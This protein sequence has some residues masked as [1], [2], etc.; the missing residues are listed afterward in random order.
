MFLGRLTVLGGV[1]LDEWLEVRLVTTAADD[2]LTVHW[3]AAAGDC[4]V[5]RWVEALGDW[6]KIRRV[7]GEGDWWTYVEWQD[8]KLPKSKIM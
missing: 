3:V 7:A 2:W 5:V 6:F 1:D 4:L 8:Q